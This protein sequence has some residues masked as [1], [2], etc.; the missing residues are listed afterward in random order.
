MKKAVLVID[1][2]K[3]FTGEHAKMPVDKKQ[4]MQMIAHVNRLID[5]ATAKNLLI[6]YIG[7][8][9]GKLNLLNVFRNFAAIKNTEGAQQD[10]RLHVINDHYFE[11]QKGNA[12]SNAALHAFLQKENISELLITGL[13]AEHC[14]YQT[15]KGALKN[16]Y[17]TVLLTD[18]IASKSDDRLAS[19]IDKCLKLGVQKLASVEI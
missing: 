13:Y 4:T 9:Y 7:N 1:I 16:K 18:C 14:I 2:Q 15:I 3:D 19:A 12:F 11:K 8:E 6:I 10:E 17:K 5:H